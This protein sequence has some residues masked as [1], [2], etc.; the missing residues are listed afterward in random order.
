MLRIALSYKALQMVARIP[1]WP[2]ADQ[3]L[4]DTETGNSVLIYHDDKRESINKA[5][6]AA[7]NNREFLL[8]LAN[9]SRSDDSTEVKKQRWASWLRDGLINDQ[10]VS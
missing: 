6:Y 8:E 1:D 4:V 10:R 2:K 3:V 7:A 9:E 5:R